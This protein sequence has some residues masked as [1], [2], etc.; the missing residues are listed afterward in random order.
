MATVSRLAVGLT[1]ASI[2][3]VR[4]L[5]RSSGFSAQLCLEGLGGG[6]PWRWW[7]VETRGTRCVLVFHTQ[8]AD[9]PGRR[10][11]GAG[12]GCLLSGWSARFSF[13][14][15]LPSRT[16]SRSQ[17]WM[18]GGAALSPSRLDR[19]HG[20][21][22]LGASGYHD[23]E[24]CLMARSCGSHMGCRGQAD[25]S[26]GTRAVSRKSGPGH[27]LKLPLIARAH[28]SRSWCDPSARGW[29]VRVPGSTS[30]F[31]AASE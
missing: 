13:P 30:R 19:W 3:R 12:R 15:L 28:W 7:C 14:L 11:G 31:L 21:H 23:P 8:F 24:A 26:H 17:S 18:R 20:M 16:L 6:Q 27:D 4:P 10:P 9:R 1:N 22:H 2:I 25:L 5:R 29:A